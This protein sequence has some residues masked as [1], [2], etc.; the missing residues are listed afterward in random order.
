MEIPVQAIEAKSG[1]SW[2]EA[3]EAATGTKPVAL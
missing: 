3:W 1:V 2:D